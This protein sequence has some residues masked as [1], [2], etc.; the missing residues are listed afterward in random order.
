MKLYGLNKCTTCQK[1]I[2]W[3][4]QRKIAHSSSDVRDTPITKDQVAAWSKTLGGWE[5]MINRGGFTWCGLP[6][7]ETASL[8]ETKAVALAVQHPALIRRPLIEHA[9]GRVTV[10]FSK[11]VMAGLG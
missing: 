3:L 11:Q 2:V 4:D 9:D 6:A 8:N 5:T 1:A 7:A 10:G